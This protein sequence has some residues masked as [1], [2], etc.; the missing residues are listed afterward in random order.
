[1]FGDKR[2]ACSPGV[3][4]LARGRSCVQARAEDPY[5]GPPHFCQL[6]LA[7]MQGPPSLSARLALV[8]HCCVWARA[9]VEGMM[10]G[11]RAP[12]LLHSCAVCSLAGRRAYDKVCVSSHAYSDSASDQCLIV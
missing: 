12:V 7:C 4:G 8:Q 2:I 1:M 5:A 6:E 10:E 9:C 11:R 3:L